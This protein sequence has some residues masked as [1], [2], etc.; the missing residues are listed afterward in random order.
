MRYKLKSGQCSPLVLLCE[1]MVFG[2]NFK[3]NW[4]IPRAFP[5][6]TFCPA[7]L[8]YNRYNTCSR[9]LENADSWLIGQ[10][11]KSYLKD[12]DRRPIVN[13]WGR[14]L[15]YIIMKLFGNGNKTDIEQFSLICLWSTRHNSD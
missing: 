12:T 6:C 10:R 14:D 15:I 5:N 3:I 13:L 4:A 2:L 11:L 7:S 9:A 1:Q 8:D